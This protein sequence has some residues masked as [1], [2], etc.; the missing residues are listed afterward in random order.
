MG[1]AKLLAV[2]PGDETT[3]TLCPPEMDDNVLTIPLL[4][5]S[6]AS[7]LSL[8]SVL[9]L[10]SISRSMAP[11]LHLCALSRFTQSIGSAR[12]GATC[13]TSLAPAL[14]ARTPLFIT[15]LRR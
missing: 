15:N 3:R 7:T 10:T 12:R 2:P 11:L 5:Q 6:L 1:S 9:F 4:E 14:I 8:R 13:L